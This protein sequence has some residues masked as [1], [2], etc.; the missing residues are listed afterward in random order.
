M[1]EPELTLLDGVRWQGT[2]VAGGRAHALLAA[3]VL[4]APR[5]VTAADLVEQVWAEDEP[6]HPDK[7][8]QVLVSRVRSNTA[9]DVVHHQGN[10]YHI[11]LRPDQVDAS[12]LRGQVTEAEAARA[13]GD[14]DVARHQARQAADL[15]VTTPPVD[16]PVAALVAEALELQARARR[17]LG[18][19]LLA[20]GDAAQA[21]PLLED[22]LARDP[23]DET[24][25]A[26]VLRAESSVRG[27]PPA[28]ARYAA[29]AERMRDDL[30]A[31]PGEELRR[32][33]LDLLARDAPVREGLKYDAAPMVGRD[34][35]VASIR[36]LLE[37]SRVVSVVGAGG[38]G[39]TRMAHLVGRLAQQP[40]VYFVELAGVTTPED[41][42]PEVASVLGVRESVTNVRTA[43]LRADLRS[44]VAE[45]LSGPPTLLILDNCEH[46]V[47]AAADLVA[48][49]VA[50]T[51][52]TSVL[53]T[54]RAP[55]G[56]A[57][58]QVYLLPQLE[59]VDAV[60]L[61]EQRARAARSD[62]RL[63]PDEVTELVTRLDGLPLAIELA[64]AKV[65]VM[66]V[67]EIGRRL[68]DRFALLAGR[69]RSAPDRHQTLEAVIAWSWNLLRAEDQGALQTLS[70]FPDGFSLDGAEAVLGADAL[71][72]LAELVDQSLLVVRE[73]EQVRYRFLETVRE[74]GVKQLAASDGLAAARDRLRAWAVDTARASTSRLFGRD[75]VAAMGEVR[76]EVGN[77]TGVMRSAIE[78]RDV[79]TVVPLAGTLSGFWTIEG[80]HLGVH[81]ISQPVLDLIVEQPPAPDQDL[82]EVRG[83]L[84][85]LTV[86]ATIFTGSPP[87]DALQLLREIGLAGDSSRTDVLA[88][89]ILEVYADGTPSLE[90]LDRLCDDPD[91]GL[92]RGALQWATQVRENSGDLAG[93]IEASSRALLLSDASE[94]PWT[95]ALLDSQVSGLATQAGDWDLAVEHASR[96]LPVMR[97]LG[98]AEDAVQLRSILA[99]ADIAHGRLDEAARV[100][101]EIVSD[102]RTYTTIGWS[103]TGI[104]G[105]AELAL[106]RGDV[107]RGL[108]L[109]LDCITMATERRVGFAGAS[110]LL[111]PWV[112]FAEASAL[113]A[114]VL[115]GRRQEARSLAERVRLKLPELLS[116]SMPLLDYPVLGGVL[117]AVGCWELAGDL[118]EN[119][120]DAAVRLVALGQRFGYHR[121]LPTMAWTNVHAVADAVVPG[122]LDKL[123]EEYAGQP[124]A[125]LRGE[126][127]EAVQ[128]LR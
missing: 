87:E 40:V 114:H 42:L 71:A 113:F 123:V 50:S 23:G 64:A 56:I 73:G 82:A 59:D 69:D 46:L 83:V 96:A 118:D 99:F 28:L 31:E 7:A 19:V 115:H 92:A 103:V 26:E 10:G 90:A 20:R 105:E 65:R 111:M 52:S 116:D 49:L 67:A 120:R 101:D 75:Q 9:P 45:Q 109:Y 35:D 77:L 68:E 2:P 94:G 128:R 66:S 4:A 100:I 47:E 3:L 22:A 11:G 76:A 53:T 58:E 93:A 18:S 41:V 60:R 108:R 89:L 127:T 124:A 63:D 8:L 34:D 55:L 78:D 117:L 27:V 84:A 54:S 112:L 119:R 15:V 32:L 122:A 86:T 88:R 97:A 79:R 37:R 14:L 80:D 25:L 30:G 48:F 6:S 91:P 51:D 38:L 107:D 33:H 81:A 104:T 106:A 24:R 95:R 125:D 57:A 98:A 29:Y 13:A 74:Y 121:T 5:T 39:K 70:V 102:E 12:R 62:V 43:Q 61:F 36:A 17:L 44:R 72:A 126:A 85:A 21:L 110:T 1:S 16:G